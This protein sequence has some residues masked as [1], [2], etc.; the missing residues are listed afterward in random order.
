MSFYIFNSQSKTTKEIYNKNA[1]R[2][3]TK[4]SKEIGKPLIPDMQEISL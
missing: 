2:N 4:R 3:L 1:K